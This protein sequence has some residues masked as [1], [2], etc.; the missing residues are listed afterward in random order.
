MPNI[1]QGL[2]SGMSSTPAVPVILNYPFVWSL[3]NADKQSLVAR[4]RA[5]SL[6][7]SPYINPAHMR[8]G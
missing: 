5:M 6:Q 8:P 3:S 4:R 2:A 7:V 1:S